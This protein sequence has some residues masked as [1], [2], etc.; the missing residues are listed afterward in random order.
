MF[1]ALLQRN[2]EVVVAAAV[3]TNN[4]SFVDQRQLPGSPISPNIKRTLT[5]ALL[6]GL[7][8]SVLCAFVV[9]H[10]D[11]TIKIPRGHRTPARNSHPGRHSK[12]QTC[13]NTGSSGDPRSALSESYRSLCTALQFST[14]GGIPK[15]LVVTSCRPSEGKSTTT[16]TLAKNHAAMGLVVLVVDGDLRNP[17]LHR[18]LKTDNSFGLSNYLSGGCKAE[19]A[20]QATGIPNL[21]L[22]ASGPLPP[23]PAELLA[24]PKLQ[25]LLSFGAEEFDL[26]IIDAP[27]VLGLAD[28]PLLASAAAGTL[29]VVAASRLVAIR[30][31]LRLSAS[32]L[33]VPISLVRFSASST[34]RMSGTA[35]LCVWLR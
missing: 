14:A 17:S 32:G 20:L 9:E 28:T 15:T 13:Q 22:M 5:M 30:Y 6:L 16:L 25:S 19:D 27:P 26:V 2:R 3:G 34:P 29:L 21:I 35:M 18:A 23:N 4:I 11:D 8:A 31:A 10:L 24:G 1:E 33:P 12:G 7:F